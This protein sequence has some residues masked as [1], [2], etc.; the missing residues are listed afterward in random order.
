MSFLQFF[1][2]AQYLVAKKQRERQY[3]N[4]KSST[5]GKAVDIRA[6]GPFRK[7]KKQKT[8]QKA[9]AAIVAHSKQRAGRT[10]RDQERD[11]YVIRTLLESDPD[12]SR[13]SYRNAAP[14]M[15]QGKP[16]GLREVAFS[17]IPE[18]LQ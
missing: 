2:D 16:T 6:D 9:R 10:K 4:S 7:A 18:L 17:T 12:L 11:A 1:S 5:P 3:D 13:D 14:G 15:E 8:K